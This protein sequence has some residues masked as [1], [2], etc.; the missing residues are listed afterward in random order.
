[1]SEATILVLK[2]LILENLVPEQLLLLR[3]YVLDGV[4]LLSF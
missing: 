2:G 4:L 1:M 3:Y